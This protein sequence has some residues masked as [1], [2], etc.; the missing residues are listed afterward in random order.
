MKIN[1]FNPF[2]KKKY[3]HLVKVNISESNIL[4]NIQTFQKAA[5]NWKISPVL[6]SNAYG[7]DLELVTTIL[8]RINVDFYCADSLF[9]ALKIAEISDRDILVMG[10]TPV[11]NILNFNNK[12]IVYS[13]GSMYE[14]SEISKLLRTPQRFHLKFNTGMN[15][16]GIDVKE[17][18]SVLALLT[19]NHNIL[20]D[21]VFSHFADADNTD[22]AASL[23]QI[24]S[25]NN[26]VNIFKVKMPNVTKYHM[27]ATSGVKLYERINAS[28]LRLGLG[29]YGFDP[30]NK[31]EL[32]PVMQ[33]VSKV[34]QIRNIKKGEGVGYN[35]TF[36]AEKD[37]Q[38]A[39]VPFGYYEGFPRG[40]SNFGYVKIKDVYCPI[41]GRV[42]MNVITIDVSNVQNIKEGDG[43]ILI[44][45]NK[46][47]R[48]SIPNIAKIC[49]TIPYE[50]LV[51]INGDLKRFLS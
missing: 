43:V 7:H 41:I 18:E 34:T 17:L 50:I 45:N 30:N 37:M 44:S 10:A 22:E 47:D 31:I 15:R 25:W 9:E 13:I 24:E 48:N 3:E 35:F 5:P 11:H 32:S 12:N 21:G 4:H 26:L 36:I 14:L 19:N 2:S 29:M 16:R 23:K 46:D 28:H 8:E 51:K 49:N 33:V 6:K 1:I 20:V 38:I 39:T 27:S 42:S 40:L